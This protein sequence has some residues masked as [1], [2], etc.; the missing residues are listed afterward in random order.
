MKISS[1]FG[2]ATNC[3]HI[4]RTEVFRTKRRISENKQFERAVDRTFNAYCVYSHHLN[5]WKDAC[6]PKTPTEEIN[7]LWLEAIRYEDYVN[8]LLDILIFG[9]EQEKADVLLEKAKEVLEIE[10]RFGKSS[11]I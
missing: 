10:T 5:N 1:D 6:S 7:P 3:K 2:L 9:T 4:T 11:T 8:E